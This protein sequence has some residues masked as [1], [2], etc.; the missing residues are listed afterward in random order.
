MTESTK[1]KFNYDKYLSKAK[2]YLSDKEKS[3]KLLNDA[4]DKSH[5]NKNSLTDIWDDLQLIFSMFRH[6]IKGEYKDM[7]TRSIVAIIA[8]IIYFVS[9]IDFIPDFIF[10][11]GFVDDAA[12]LGFTF[13][14]ISKDLD[15]FKEWQKD[16]N[17]IEIDQ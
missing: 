3:T 9:P 5:K 4:T 6:W 10:A 1:E 7:P 16:Q 2:D 13:K 14:Q 8:A 11:L 12:V 15:K 17:V